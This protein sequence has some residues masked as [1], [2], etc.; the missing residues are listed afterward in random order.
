MPCGWN[1]LAVDMETKHFV[2]TT[3]GR[4]PFFTKPHKKLDNNVFIY[5]APP[6][7]SSRPVRPYPSATSCQCSPHPL[8][9]WSSIEVAVL[10]TTNLSRY[11][12]RLFDSPW[13]N[14][15]SISP[16][17]SNTYR[18]I[19]YAFVGTFSLL[20]LSRGPKTGIDTVKFMSS[21]FN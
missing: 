1:W 14:N 17:L 19:I 9:Y 10:L 2:L 4:G 8:H 13:S 3:N 5:P 11:C 16:V 20:S 7:S 21:E 12:D 18:F 15:C 6:R